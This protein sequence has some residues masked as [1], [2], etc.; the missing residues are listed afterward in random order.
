MRVQAQQFIQE[1]EA[2]RRM[3]SRIAPLSSACSLIP[4]RVVARPVLAFISALSLI[5]F[6]L[7]GNLFRVFI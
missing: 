6:T 1:R 3:A 2:L 7:S 5:L 4:L